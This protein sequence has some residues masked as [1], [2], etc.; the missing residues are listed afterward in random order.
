M[1]CV[2]LERGVAGKKTQ[3]AFLSSSALEV[4]YKNS[5]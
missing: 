5:T 1:R 3:V 2:L 4:I